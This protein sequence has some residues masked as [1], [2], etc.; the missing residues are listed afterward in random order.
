MYYDLILNKMK[1]KITK[2]FLALLALSFGNA[3]AQVQNRPVDE[4]QPMS[5]KIRKATNFEFLEQFA[6]EKEAEYQKAVKVATELNMPI[7]KIEDGRVVMLMGYDEESK[8]LLYGTTHNNSTTGSS[9]QTA[10]AKPLHTDGIRG[11]GMN[12]GVWDGGIAVASHLAFSSGRYIAKQSTPVDDHAAHV[13]GTVGAGSFT[14]GADVMGFA[15]QARIYGWDYSNDISEMTTAAN[16]TSD[17]IYVSNHSYGYDYV[18]N[19]GPVS[20]LGQYSAKTREYDQLAYNAPYYTIVTSAG[21]SRGD[22]RIPQKTGGKDLLSWAASAKNTI[23]V[24]ATNGTEN[25]T[26]ITG[27]SSVNTI[28]GVAPFIAGFSSYGPTDDFRIK[29]DIAAKGVNVKSVGINGLTSTAVMSGTSMSSPAVTGVVTLWQGYY[30]Q[31]NT[32]YMRSA[33]VR[34]LMAH[35]AR[36]AGPAAGPD[37][38]FG[39]GLI[40]ADKGRQVIDQAK[41][42]TALFRELELP[43]GATFEYEFSYD[44]V[45]PLVATIAWTDPAGTVT[46]QTD[47][48]IKKLVNDLDLR[49]INTDTNVTYYPWSLVQQWA[50]VPSSTSIAVNTVDNARDNI[51]KIEPQSAVAGNYKIVVNHKGALQG[52][53][54]HYTLIIS[55]AGGTMPA[56]DG[57]ASAENIILQN[58]NIYPNPTDSYL[59]INGDLETLMNASAQIFDISGKKVQDVNLNFS[60]NNATIDVSSLRTGTYILTLS[61]GE[62]KKSYKFIKK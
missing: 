49:L 44:G 45:A 36:E 60:S 34:A 3:H 19:N 41:A 17:P 24:A 37:F 30:K 23:V 54:Q 53:N 16:N 61:K 15:T 57:K 42:E 35:T 38:M 55:G 48:N 22:G 7:R 5:D 43:N 13:A 4:I 47:L 58:L 18:G 28:G 46:T 9:L 32:D 6:K 12:V 21:N 11:A 20:I 56:T 27:P 29:P 10:N 14:G 59:N 52:G 26:G 51:E 31:V 1:N 40:D 2:L 8:Q 33:S 62:A 39:W 50:I 25:F